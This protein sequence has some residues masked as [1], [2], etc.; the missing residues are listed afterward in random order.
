MSPSGT[1]KRLKV[2]EE[3]GLPSPQNGDAVP[4]SADLVMLS[5]PGGVTAESIRQLRT[6]IIAQHIERGRRALAFCA[7]NADS[8]CSFIAANTAVAFA[9]IGTR[10]LFINADLRSN[11]QGPLFTAE[12]AHDGLLHYLS[13]TRKPPEPIVEFAALPTLSLIAAGGTGENA[14]ELLSS[15]RFADLIS[16]CVREFDLTIIDTPPAN[17]YADAQRVAALAGYAVIVGRTH[18]TYYNDITELGR[19]LTTDGVSVLGTV[20]NDH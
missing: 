2:V 19:Q 17:L 3:P 8:G 13:A 6:R 5:D 20:L 1:A 9:Q 16:T 11:D 12:E 10:V 18:K 7:P 15:P 14:Q 4:V